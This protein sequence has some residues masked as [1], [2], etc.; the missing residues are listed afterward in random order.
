MA[1]LRWTTSEELE[2][3]QNELPEFLNMQKDQKLTCFYELLFPRWFSL[4]LEHLKYWKPT[5]NPPL[6]EGEAVVHQNDDSSDTNISD[7]SGLLPLTPEQEAELEGEKEI[8]QKSDSQRLRI[9]PVRWAIQLWN[10]AHASGWAKCRCHSMNGTIVMGHKLTDEPSWLLTVSEEGTSEPTG[11]SWAHHNTGKGADWLSTQASGRAQLVLTFN[12]RI[13]PA[14]RASQGGPQYAG[15]S[16]G[17]TMKEFPV[18]M[19]VTDGPSK[20][21]WPTGY[22]YDPAQRGNIQSHLLFGPVHM[23]GSLGWAYRWAQE[24]MHLISEG[25]TKPNIWHGTA[26]HSRRAS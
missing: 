16:G 21:F 8:R 2:W 26:L 9:D 7:E 25:P 5:G 19:G 13:G 11:Y 22:A 4:F 18:V 20:F 1:P 15:K 24:N 23:P 3:L 17:P 10:S 12:M 14:D 6:H